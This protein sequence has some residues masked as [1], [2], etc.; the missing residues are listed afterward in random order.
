MGKHDKH[1]ETVRRSSEEFTQNRIKDL[2][3]RLAFANETIKKLQTEVS[4]Y[5]R[6]MNEVEADAK[7]RIT[8]L[9]EENTMLREKIAKLV[10][11]YV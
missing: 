1:D 9:E 5:N 4:K 7:D 10:E 6:W 11:I 8:E 3:S 2:E